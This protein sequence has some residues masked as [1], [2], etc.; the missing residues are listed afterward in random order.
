VILAAIFGRRAAETNIRI[1]PI[2]IHFFFIA[3]PLYQ[4]FITMFSYKKVIDSGILKLMI[5]IDSNKRK[6]RGKFPLLVICCV[7]PSF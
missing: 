6:K 1:I 3:F 5:L 4:Y 7:S 2:A